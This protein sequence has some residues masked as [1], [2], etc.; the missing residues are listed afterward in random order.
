LT[1]PDEWL[2]EFGIMRSQKKNNRTPRP[3]KQKHSGSAWTGG[4]RENA[5]K[6]H[7]GFM[8]RPKKAGGEGKSGEGMTEPHDEP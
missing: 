1:R 8:V 2:Y 7:S 3:I 6:L 4:H 5:F